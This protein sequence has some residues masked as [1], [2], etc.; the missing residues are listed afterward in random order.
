[1]RIYNLIIIS[2]K[3]TFWQW[4]WFRDVID[5]NVSCIHTRRHTRV[6]I[7]KTTHTHTRV[8]TPTDP[9]VQMTMLMNC[10]SIKNTKWGK[11]KCQICVRRCYGWNWNCH[12]FDV[13][14]PL[15]FQLASGLVLSF[16]CPGWFMSTDWIYIYIYIYISLISFYSPLDAIF[17]YLSRIIK[18]DMHTLLHALTH[19]HIYV[20]IR[21]NIEKYL[22]YHRT[23]SKKLWSHV[24]ETQ[25]FPN[26]PIIM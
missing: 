20:Y 9:V 19:S 23:P 8:Y 26:D 18:Y 3:N 6:H 10:V 4:D 25:L 16:G 15:H 21:G 12:F 5:W 13:M 17:I 7:Q 24:K 14:T 22:I 11:N 1:M 2:H